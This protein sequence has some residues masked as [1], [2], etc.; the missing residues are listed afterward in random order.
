[1]AELTISVRAILLGR[2]GGPPLQ[3]TQVNRILVQL[4]YSDSYFMQALKSGGTNIRNEVVNRPLDCLSDM[5]LNRYS[6]GS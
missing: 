6:D 5:D 1:M 4:K 3:L 2:A